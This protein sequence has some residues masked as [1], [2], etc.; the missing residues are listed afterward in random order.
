MNFVSKSLLLTSVA[1]CTG[2]YAEHGEDPADAYRQVTGTR[3]EIALPASFEP[4][5]QGGGFVDPMAGLIVQ[6]SELPNPVEQ[7]LFTFHSKETHEQS[8]LTLISSEDRANG[9]YHGEYFLFR[10]KAGDHEVFK[11]I[12][13]FGTDEQCAYVTGQAQANAP[14]EVRKQLQ[15]YVDSAR[16][17]LDLDADPLADLPYEFTRMKE[18]KLGAK[19]S[20]SAVFVPSASS[21]MGFEAPTQLKVVLDS[22]AQTLTLREYAES[23]LTGNDL[24]KKAS[25][26]TIEPIELDGLSG[27]EVYGSGL[28]ADGSLFFSY[29]IVLQEGMRPIRIASLH[30]LAD[31]DP[32]SYRLESMAMSF[33]RKRRSIEHERGRFSIEVPATWNAGQ[34]EDEGIGVISLQLD[35]GMGLLVLQ[36]PRAELPEIKSLRAYAEA[37]STLEDLGGRDFE[38]FA[39]I[40]I[41]SYRAVQSSFVADIEGNPH[42]ILHTV[43]ED[44]SNYFNV[45]LNCHAIAAKSS[46]P[47][48]TAILNSFRLKGAESE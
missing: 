11:I 26:K 30:G 23:Q 15:E 1:L 22:G 20:T 9:D 38:P 17:S 12:W 21:V 47:D 6:A 35:A 43:F 4:L 25:V 42:K 41:G 40:Q 8:G 19:A 44:E 36:E 33:Q 13:A 46:I 37:S 28:R 29:D 48:L 45:T 18:M 34:E 39:E 3:V 5:G 14:E 32:M 7:I 10:Q 31:K 2:V 16:W 27:F 24:F